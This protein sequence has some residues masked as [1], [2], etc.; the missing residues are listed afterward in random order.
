[1]KKIIAGCFVLVSLVQAQRYD[2]FLEYSFLSGCVGKDGD[3][4]AKQC[5][6]MLS[7]I[8][9]TTTQTEMIEFS[10]KAAQG[11]EASKELNAKIM[12]AAMKCVER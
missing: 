6:C 5:V 7:E 2:M 1:M 9:K 4:K 10:L 8:E 12:G 11:Q 3:A